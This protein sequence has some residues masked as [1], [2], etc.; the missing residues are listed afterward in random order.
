M[1]DAP[2]AGEAF[3]TAAARH[4]HIHE[5]SLAGVA[6]PIVPSSTFLLN[7]AAHSSRLAAKLGQPTS[8]L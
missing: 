4:Y 3:A 7:N 5:A 6:P 8:R 2:G 1:I